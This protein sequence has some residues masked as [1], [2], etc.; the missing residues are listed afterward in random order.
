M[1]RITDCGLDSSSR[2]QHTVLT[3]LSHPMKL[4]VERLLGH[5][6]REKIGQKVV[7]YLLRQAREDIKGRDV[8][9]LRPSVSEVSLIQK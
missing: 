6:A 4:D 9:D 5:V 8:E 3:M 7:N 2:G 1:E